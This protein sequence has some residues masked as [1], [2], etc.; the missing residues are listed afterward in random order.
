MKYILDLT[1]E[2]T[3]SRLTSSFLGDPDLLSVRNFGKESPRCG[4]YG[5][6]EETL[7][8]ET[9]T[10]FLKQNKVLGHRFPTVHLA[11]SITE[12][13]SGTEITV[14]Y[15]YS[16]IAYIILGL[17]ILGAVIET[18]SSGFIANP[19]AAGAILFFVFLNALNK[20][21]KE[22]LKKEFEWIYI[23]HMFEANSDVNVE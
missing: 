7:S 22:E 17:L 3:L 12:G 5:R 2:D 19:F 13:D 20:N 6:I 14:N 9:F 15:E 23:G 11:G 21:L 18:F 1:K 8:G 10:M 4:I 16:A